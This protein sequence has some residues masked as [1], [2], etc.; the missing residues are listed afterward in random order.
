MQDLR[1]ASGP[2]TDL[3][4]GSVEKNGLHGRVAVKQPILE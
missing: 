1:D 4:V 2:L 3:S